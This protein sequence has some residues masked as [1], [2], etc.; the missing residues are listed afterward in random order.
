LLDLKRREA[1][2]KVNG[3]PICVYNEDW[4]I[5]YYSAISLNAL[6]KDLGLMHETSNKYINTDLLYLDCFRL[7]T[8]LK[9]EARQS[10]MPISELK[11]L[12]KAKRQEARV[13]NLKDYAGHGKIGISVQSEIT[14]EVKILPSY[15][16]ALEYLRSKGTNMSFKTLIKYLEGG[17]AYKGYIF[18][19]A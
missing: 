17:V 13:T 4:T 15:A 18:K 19:K 10:S 12:I 3:K 2:F 7:A 8:E 16:A 14:G 11:D 5:L 6:K 9:P 1:L